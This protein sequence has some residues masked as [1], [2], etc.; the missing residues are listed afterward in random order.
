MSIRDVGI[1][2]I[3]FTFINFIPIILKSINRIFAP[4][5]SEIWE[6]KNTQELQKLYHF[7]TKWTLILSFPIVFFIIV[8]N[9]ELYAVIRIR[10]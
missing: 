7:F 6:Q 2:Y 8:F 5:I 4:N 3:T 1:Y 9:K 10:L